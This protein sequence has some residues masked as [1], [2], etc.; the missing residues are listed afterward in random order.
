MN[1]GLRETLI[2]SAHYQ[3]PAQFI[4][5]FTLFREMLLTVGCLFLRVED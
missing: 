4:G 2:H 3:T 5:R 1:G